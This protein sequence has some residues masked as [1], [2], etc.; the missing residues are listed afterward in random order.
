M[1]T[2]TWRDACKTNDS[3][4]ILCALLDSMFPPD[5]DAKSSFLL[6]SAIEALAKV[7]EG[8]KLE[9]HWDVLCFILHCQFT[10]TTDTY[11]AVASAC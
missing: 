5:P 11:V 2:S 10:M 8:Y 6:S 4:G 7:R 1:S 3:L 9:K